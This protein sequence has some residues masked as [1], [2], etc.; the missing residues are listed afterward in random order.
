MKSSWVYI[1]NIDNSVRY[2]LGERGKR[3]LGCLGINPSTAEPDALDNTLRSVKRIATSNSY[4]GW[5][6]LNV[7][8]QRATDPHDLH[9]DLDTEIQQFNNYYVLKT[10]Q[11]LKINALWL[12]FGDLINNRSYLPFCLNELNEVLIPLNLKYKIVGEPTI[13][14]NPRHP[15]YLPGDSK[16]IDF[17]IQSYMKQLLRQQIN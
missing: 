11:E 7:Y 13:K 1:S 14:G 3:M 12:A 15:L 8:P 17:D 10:I 9:Q 2:V 4:D 16:L 6:M 5:I